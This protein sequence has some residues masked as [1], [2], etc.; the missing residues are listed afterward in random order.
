[1]PT[2]I[3]IESHPV[4]F[5][6]R[7]TG[8]DHLYLVR[9]STDA[10]GRIRSETVIRGGLG[11]DGSLTIQAGLPL[12]LSEDSRGGDTP[13]DRHQRI[14]DLGGRSANDVWNVMLQHARNVEQAN[15]PYG[16][17]FLGQ[18]DG[19]DVNS[20]TL[21]ASVLFSVGISLANNLPP[22][23][24]PGEVPLYDQV[25]AMRVNDVLTGT[26]RG[27]VIRG[28]TGDDQVFGAS[29]NDALI[30]DR[31]N[32]RLAG[33]SGLDRL[34]GGT[35]ND[36]LN[37]GIG[38]DVMAGGSGFDAFVFSNQIAG[39]TNVDRVKDF[40]VRDDT[41]WLSDRVFGEVGPE[42]R[43]R[44]TAFWT[45]TAAHDATDRIVH[46]RATGALYY[47][48]DGFGAADQIQFAQ[49][50]AGLRITAADFLIV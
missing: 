19:G 35:G 20:N 18:L 22:T 13:A 45:G 34:S 39:G 11:P 21:V 40:S 30:G 37:G 16:Y 32:D 10:E 26:A 2:T 42:G 41:I 28:G 47:D 15:L 38:S 27:D 50:N 3:A 31:G 14:L 8:F 17:D 29:G 48:P 9:T 36:W 33:Q 12:A 49:L 7:D 5:H 24:R 6:G 44:T 25:A 46:D 43:L 4:E 23:V 1:V